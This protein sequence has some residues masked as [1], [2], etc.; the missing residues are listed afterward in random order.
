MLVER[1]RLEGKATGAQGPARFS[2]GSEKQRGSAV[3][4][5]QA[6]R[7]GPKCWKCNS[8]GNFQR[9]CKQRNYSGTVAVVSAVENQSRNQLGPQDAKVKVCSD[10]T[11]GSKEHKDVI[12]NS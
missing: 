4:G 11:V 8:W 7:V 5:Q 3:S 10:Q 6:N 2:R 1:Q 12:I 9:D